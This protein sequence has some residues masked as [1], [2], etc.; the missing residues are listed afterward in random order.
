ME[1][2]ASIQPPSIAPIFPKKRERCLQICVI[3]E[4]DCVHLSKVDGA[5]TPPPPADDDGIGGMVT[6]YPTWSM[7]TPSPE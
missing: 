4:G 2:E 3:G 7:V 1:Q 6:A 5:L